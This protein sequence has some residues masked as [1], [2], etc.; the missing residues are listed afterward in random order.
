L[1]SHKSDAGQYA[2]YPQK[3]VQ[4]VLKKFPFGNR[5]KYPQKD[6][7]QRTKPISKLKYQQ[8]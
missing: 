6:K 8:F 7:A 4:L 3:Q 5:A 2:D 1:S